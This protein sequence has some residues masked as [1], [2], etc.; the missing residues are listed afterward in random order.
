MSMSFF[1]AFRADVERYQGRRALLND[2]YGAALLDKV[3]RA[4]KDN[5]QNFGQP[6]F[7]IVID[8]EPTGVVD[9]K[10]AV[11]PLPYAFD[12]DELLADEDEFEAVYS[13]ISNGGLLSLLPVDEDADVPDMAKGGLFET[14]G[15]EASEKAWDTLELVVEKVLSPVADK[16]RM[17]LA[18]QVARLHDGA[19]LDADFAA[20]GGQGNT[21]QRMFQ[22]LV[23]APERFAQL[24]YLAAQSA[25]DEMVQEMLA[26]L[27]EE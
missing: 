25:T 23:D 21:A 17:K 3:K 10:G 6:P 24:I 1:E 2:D 20:D 8:H 11:V 27:Q 5:G 4:S 7:L 19:V 26:Y 15:S 13:A 18:A 14:L 16:T 9:A 12:A 22:E